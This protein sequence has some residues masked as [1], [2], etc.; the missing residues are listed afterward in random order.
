MSGTD[1]DST[2]PGRAGSRK[3]R[4]AT[5]AIDEVYERIVRT[6]RVGGRLGGAIALYALSQKW[7]AALYAQH[8]GISPDAA[9]RDLGKLVGVNVLACIEGRGRAQGGRD[10][11][12]Y[13]LTEFGARVLSRCPEVGR[14]RRVRAPQVAE[15]EPVRTRSGMHK[16]KRSRKAAQDAHDLYCTQLGEHYG[17]LEDPDWV[18]Q[19][20]VY[21]RSGRK[22]TS[23]VPDFYYRCDDHLWAIE[24]EGTVERAAVR[25][26]HYR[27]RQFAQFLLQQEGGGLDVHLTIVFTSRGV[28]ERA[29]EHHESAY[30]HSRRFY[31]LEWVDLDRALATGGEVE[32]LDRIC[33]G[34]H[35]QA[36]VD[37]L[38]ERVRRQQL[39]LDRARER[40]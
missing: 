37:A 28:R 12:V 9:R 30:G 34:V 15:G 18:M 40:P 1:D 17:L 20:R 4:T 31:W 24:V 5:R 27:Y 8:F 2:R 14:S 7:T 22:T 26:K 21:F 19:R 38:Q 33:V 16:Y 3:A 6:P 29:M 35:H 39:A 32:E 13:V 25:K 11:D 23:L 36:V 10:P